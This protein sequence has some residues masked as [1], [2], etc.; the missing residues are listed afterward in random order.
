MGNIMRLLHELHDGIKEKKHRILSHEVQLLHS[1]SPV[2]STVV[3]KEAE[4]KCADK[5]AV[6][7][8]HLPPLH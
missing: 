4:K 3:A 7:E 1:N 2:H 6:K 5:N 8:L